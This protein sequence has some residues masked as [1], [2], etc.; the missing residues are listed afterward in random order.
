MKRLRSILATIVI[1]LTV[2]FV[3]VYW[4]APIALSFYEVRMA[5]PVAKVV[6]TQLKDHSISQA[7]GMRLS[8][9]GYDF[10]V[11]WDDI[12]ES[13]TQLYPKDS[14]V[15][16]MVVLVFRSG[17]KIMVNS[18]HPREFAYM[19]EKDYKM[20]ARNM[21]AIFGPGSANSD[22]IFTKNVWAFTPDKMHHWSLTPAMYA[23]E[24]MLLM[25]K[26]V[27]PSRA[28]RSGIFN[29]RTRDY[30]G[31]QQGNL[32]VARDGVLVTLFANDGGVEFLFDADHYKNPVGLTQP[33]INRVVQTLRKTAAREE[34][35]SQAS[36][37]SN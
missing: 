22:Y 12:D 31:F 37:P 20:P 17:L 29:V 5:P 10:E 35:S 11:P 33:E 30:V 2:I 16:T 6:P 24:T 26:S 3:C 18:L 15:K 13:K 36:R 21:D 7:P 9:V 8:Y 25:F 4:I 1:T 34:A 19:W 27:M 32:E 14:S 23:R 28:A